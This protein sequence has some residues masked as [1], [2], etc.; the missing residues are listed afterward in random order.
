LHP[1]PL[2]TLTPC[3]R[4][5]VVAG[6][7]PQATIA[8]VFLRRRSSISVAGIA[9]S[10]DTWFGVKDKDRTQA[11]WFVGWHDGFCTL[12]RCG[13]RGVEEGERGGSGVGV[14]E[15]EKRRR[16][17]IV[18]WRGGRLLKRDPTPLSV[19]HAVVRGWR[20]TMVCAARCLT[21]RWF[22]IVEW[23]C[24][25]WFGGKVIHGFLKRRC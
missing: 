14:G 12:E 21:V 25:T 6:A 10:D 4:T 13:R 9:C 18:W 24:A 2:T 7:K 11:W 8:R 3:T 15:G 23:E 19:R 20:G 17:V 5:E 22:L 16:A 1:T